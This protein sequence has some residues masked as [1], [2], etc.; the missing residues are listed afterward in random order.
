MLTGASFRDAIVF[1]GVDEVDVEAVTAA[2]GTVEVVARGRLSGAECP[3]RGRFSD[4]LQWVF[5]SVSGSQALL[6]S[7]YQ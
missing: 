3:D 4:R 6:F 7:L 5:H 2:F 1:G